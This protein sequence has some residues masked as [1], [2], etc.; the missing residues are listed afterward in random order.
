MTIKK[1][2]QLALYTESGYHSPDLNN[3][4]LRLVRE[5][6]QGCY[7][8]LGAY[9]VYCGAYDDAVKLFS[10]IM[11]MIRSVERKK[12]KSYSGE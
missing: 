7:V 4:Q 3:P 5:N 2:L 11:K 10:G 9:G 1:N 6:T 8:Y 12:M